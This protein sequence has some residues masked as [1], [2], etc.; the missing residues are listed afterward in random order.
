[1]SP[2]VLF[3]PPVINDLPKLLRTATNGIL[4]F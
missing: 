1:L 2:I 3:S 4:R